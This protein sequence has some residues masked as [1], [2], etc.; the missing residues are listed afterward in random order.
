MSVRAGSRPHS[1]RAPRP[2]TLTVLTLLRPRVRADAGAGE[3][4]GAGLHDGRAGG[5]H[6]TR[7]EGSRATHLERH[8]HR[9]GVAQ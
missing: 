1:L 6:T 4:V 8:R 2:L 7:G 5:A 9:V 3:P